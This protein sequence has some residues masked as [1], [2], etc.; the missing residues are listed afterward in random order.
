MT[1][2][3]LITS[4]EGSVDALSLTFLRAQPL[5]VIASLDNIEA[6][7]RHVVGAIARR[8]FEAWKQA[9]LEAVLRVAKKCPRCGHDRA[10]KTRP[11]QP[12]HLGLLGLE[13]ELP[14]LY[15]E[16]SHCDATGVSITRLLTGLSSGDTSSELQLRAAYSAAEHSYGKASR[17][18]E[19]HYGM[20]VERTGVRR[21]ALS[22]EAEA[23]RYANQQRRT[24][25]QRVSGERRIEGPERLMLQG[26]GGTVR[27]GILVPCVPGD[28]GYRKKTP[29]T[30]KA[31]RKR[32]T[33]N[34]E[35]ITLDVR[36][37]GEM[38]PT[39]LDVVL[40]VTA[41][42]GERERR[43]LALASRK[44]LGDN[45]EMLGLGD[46]GSRLAQSFDEAFVGYTHLYSGDWKHTCD[47]VDGAAAVLRDIDAGSWAKRMKDA[48]WKRN[49][50]ARD[51]LLAQAHEHRVDQ[52]PSDCERCPVKALDTYVHNNW[53][54]LN[55]ARLKAKGLEFVSA[56][57]EAQ[58]RDRTK[59]RFRTPGA[60]R[61]ENLEGKATL[62]AI[63]ADG[64]WPEFRAFYLD[65]RARAFNARLQAAV[66][67]AIADGRLCAAPELTGFAAVNEDENVSQKAA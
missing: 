65:Q 19:V 49:A 12:M 62:R 4:V 35:L 55:A 57:A 27:T 6:F 20:A 13:V 63:I 21:M 37:P 60:W 23:L 32:L 31:R 44:G 42:P 7:S 48:L 47:Y 25:I 38:Q 30:G 8:W 45:T 67:R 56:R 64:R 46:L 22:V 14:K 18:L 3:D 43:M 1:V 39:A 33:Q 26:D 50:T 36:Q 58:V 40:P 52:L 5:A 29:K 10:C 17:D 24:A 11:G 15:L 53:R 2:A 51:A 61:E 59:S 66:V 28:P 16:C 9:L 54:Y 34:R 41:K